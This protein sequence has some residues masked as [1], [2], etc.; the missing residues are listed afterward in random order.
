MKDELYREMIKAM[1]VLGAQSDLL[2]IVCSRGDTLNDAE[3]LEELTLWN[4]VNKKD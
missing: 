3:T 4:E 1:Q 2:S